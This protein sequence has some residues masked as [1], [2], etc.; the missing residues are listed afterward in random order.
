[1]LKGAT[2]LGKYVIS[3]EVEVGHTLKVS[4]LESFASFGSYEIFAELEIS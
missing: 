4:F 3:T 1:M 2:A